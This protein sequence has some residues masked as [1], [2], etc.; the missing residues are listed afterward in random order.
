MTDAALLDR[1]SKSAPDGSAKPATVLTE[2]IVEVISDSGEGA[3][4]CGQSLGAIAARSGN[5]IWTVEI[6][7]AE[8]QPPARS[9]AGASGIRI[10]IGQNEGHERRR[11]NGPGRRVQ[12]AGAARTRARGGA[13]ARRDDPAREHVARAQGPDDRRVVRG[14]G[15][16][17]RRRRLPRHRG[18][19]RTRMPRADDRR[20]ARQEHV[21]AGHAVQHLQP[22]PDARAR[23]GRAHLRQEGRE[24]HR[25]QRAA[26]RSGLRVGRGEPPVQVRDPRGAGEG[27]ADRRQRQHGDR[28]RRARV[29]DG[30]LRDVPDHAGHV[31]VA[32]SVRRLR[33]R[34]RDGAPGRG[35]DRRVRVRDRR[36]VR[37]P[38]RGHDHVGAGLF[39][40][41][42]GPGPR[43]DGGDTARGGQR[44]AWRAFHRPAD[45]GRAGRPP[46]HRLRQPR[47]RAQGRAGGERHR[48]LLLFDDHGPQD[49]RDVQH[50]R[51]RAV[52]REPRDRAVAV[53]AAALLRGLAGAAARPDAGAGGR[54]ALRLG[55]GHRDRPPFHS[56][57]AG[58]HAHADRAR[59]RPDEQGRLRPGRSTRKACARAA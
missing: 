32:L 21:R 3:Q 45:E 46:V 58:R 39:A 6:I 40:E 24:G 51:R 1:P 33:A 4:R 20:A 55:S 27:A 47:R 41:A 42:G 16:L 12:R 50:G 38:L 54:Q 30:H 7:P 26:A 9:V 28:A 2:H 8:I 5:G 22:R 25:H 52:G 19:A 17:A 57:A 23:P 15:H 43:G 37:R 49:R 35:R 14:D 11:R 29:G 59:A 18:A 48:G 53:P 36:V 34:R 13:Q 56:R 10:R 31:G 44:A